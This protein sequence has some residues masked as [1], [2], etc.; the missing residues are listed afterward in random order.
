[1][2][3]Y[4]HDLVNFALGLAGLGISGLALRVYKYLDAL[5][6]RA[7][8]NEELLFT[9]RADCISIRRE[10]RLQPYPYDR[11]DH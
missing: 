6:T 9:V 10:S 1:M 5:E 7:D 11:Q 8:E 2:G 4:L 3:M